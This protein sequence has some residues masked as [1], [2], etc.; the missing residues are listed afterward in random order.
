M[1]VLE[2][3][4]SDQRFLELIRKALNSGYMVSDIPKI[5]LVGTPQGS[6]ISPILANIYLHELDVFVEKLKSEF[7]S[8]EERP[9]R[10]ESNRYIDQMLKAKR[11]E[12]PILREKEI[13]KY[14]YLLRTVEN[15]TVGLHTRKIMYVRYADD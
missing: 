8:P 12:D 7:D 13:R 2:K 14:T 4:I 15:K 5:D 10:K 1:C 9:I 3:R 6:V 11:I